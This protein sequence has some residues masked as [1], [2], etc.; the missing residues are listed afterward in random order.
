MLCNAREL[1]TSCKLS[2]ISKV[3]VTSSKDGT[4]PYAVC[5]ILYAVDCCE[6]NTPWVTVG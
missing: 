4:I 1:A 3:Y 6:E 2:C 5:T